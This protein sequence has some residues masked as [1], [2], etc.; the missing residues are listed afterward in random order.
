MGELNA[1][2]EFLTLPGLCNDGDDDAH[3]H[4]DDHVHHHDYYQAHYDDV[5]DDCIEYDVV[6]ANEI[7]V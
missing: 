2:Q 3:Y 6:I 1:C 5:Y 7:K 4:D